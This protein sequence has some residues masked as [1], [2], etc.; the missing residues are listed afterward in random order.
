VH[1]TALLANLYA[2]RVIDQPLLVDG[3]VELNLLFFSIEVEE[4]AG[5]V[6]VGIN[7]EVKRGLVHNL[8]EGLCGRTLGCQFKFTQ[9][10]LVSQTR[11]VFKAR[12]S[13][14]VVM[15]LSQCVEKLVQFKVESFLQDRG[16]LFIYRQH[17]AYF[18]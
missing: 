18:H 11:V 16:L 4:Q 12:S 15:R 3:I 5:S 10:N 9:H 1:S 13:M 14:H 17:L 8:A 6:K 7:Q 2:F